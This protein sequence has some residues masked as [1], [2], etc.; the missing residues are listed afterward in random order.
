MS[1]EAQQEKTQEKKEQRESTE[2]FCWRLGI[3]LI[4]GEKGGSRI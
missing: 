2:E 1:D 4:R 3:K